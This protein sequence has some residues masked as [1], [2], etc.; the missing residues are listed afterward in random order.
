[1][2][3]KV[4]E[5]STVDQQRS[6]VTAPYIPLSVLRKKMRLTLA[7]V[8]ER[9]AEETGVHHDRSTISAIENGLRGA[10]ADMIQA[11]AS[12]YEIDPAVIDTN[13]APR[14]RHGYANNEAAAS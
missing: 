3:K 11:L 1:M 9:I 4:A 10:S 14:R 12:A 8:C 2:P 13:Y 7:M 6:R 5:D